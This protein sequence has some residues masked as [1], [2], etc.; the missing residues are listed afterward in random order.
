M[1]YQLSYASPL[2]PKKNNITALELQ[3]GQNRDFVEMWKTTRPLPLFF[4]SPLIAGASLS[5]NEHR[6]G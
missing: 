1:L 3:A 2:K 4:A 5:R 6:H